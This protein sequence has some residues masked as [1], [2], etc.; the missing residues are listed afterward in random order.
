[1][2]IHYHSDCVFFAGCENMIANFLND[3][4]HNEISFSYVYSKEYQSGLRARVA[5][6][7]K[8]IYPLKFKLI[9]FMFNK[10]IP[11]DNLIVIFFYKILKLILTIPYGA[12]VF[13]RLW[14][15]FYRI[16][17]E[18]LHVNNGGYPG[19][20]TC[21][22]APLAAKAAG[23]KHVVMVVNNLAV[24]Y[25]SIAR[26]IQKPFD[27]LVSNSVDR[28]VTGSIVAKERLSEVLSLKKEHVISIYNGVNLRTSNERKEA[29]VHR[30]VNDE[31]VGLVVGVIS[32]LEKRKGHIVLLEAI[33]YLSKNK[34][35]NEKQVLFLIEGKGDEYDRLTDYVSKSG[36]SAYVRFIGHEKNI[37][38]LM[39]IIDVLVLPSI[40][41]EDFPNVIIEAMGMG[42]PV[43]ASRLAGTPEQVDIGKTGLLV[44][45]KDVQGLAEALLILIKNEDLRKA[46]G[47]NSLIKF[48]KEFLSEVSLKKYY[49]LYDELRGNKC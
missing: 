4:D 37:M 47:R 32:L 36:I 27:I 33:N 28:F 31:S 15:L 43:I 34:L 48:N 2:K 18:V 42:I 11:S 39:N 1:M 38:N 21:R 25:E 35:I 5:A 41:N 40:S 23:I 30:L 6:I 26:L 49:S 9:N 46:M 13:S 8:D 14:F 12:I 19:A 45:P 44:E 10:P 17:P 7:S 20:F 22:I 24:N 29:T 3:V 16:K